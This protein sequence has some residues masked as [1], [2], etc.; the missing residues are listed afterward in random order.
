MKTTV[1]S[2]RSVQRIYFPNVDIS[3]YM[4]GGQIG[5]DYQFAPN[6][7]VGIEGAATG[8]RIGGSTVVPQPAAIPATVQRSRKRPTS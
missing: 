7:V 3:G 8:G 4:V 2:R 1:P 5:C 6:W